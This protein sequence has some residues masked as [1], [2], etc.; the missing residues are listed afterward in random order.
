MKKKNIL[1]WIILAIALA[2]N[3][4]ILVNAFINGESSAKESNTVAEGAAVVVNTISENTVTDEN[5]S[6]FAFN[7]RKLFGHFGLFA[8]SGVFTTWALYL[9][10]KDSKVQYFA[11]ELGITF[12]FGFMWACLSEFA[13][14]FTKDRSGSWTDVGIDFGGYFIGVLLVFLILLLRKSPIFL[15]QKQKENR[16]K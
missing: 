1:K 10:V 4:F 13:Q 11:C 16:A 9:F 8:L 15:T 3:V 12:G 5:F 2:I 6:Q 7:I 14:L